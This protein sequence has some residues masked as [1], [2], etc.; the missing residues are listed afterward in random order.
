M[1]AAGKKD[2]ALLNI[3]ANEKENAGDFSTVSGN[4]SLRNSK[5]IRKSR[6]SAGIGAEK[7]QGMMDLNFQ[8]LIIRSTQ[9]LTWKQ[10]IQSEEY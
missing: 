4:S 6:P 9:S 1:S 3:V 10:M 8:S 2:E 7:W 5:A